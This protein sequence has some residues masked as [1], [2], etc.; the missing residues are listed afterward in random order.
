MHSSGTTCDGAHYLFTG[1]EVSS[2]DSLNVTP[3]DLFSSGDSDAMTL[4]L[5]FSSAHQRNS[6]QQQEV[7]EAR[8]LLKERVRDDWDYPPLPAHQLP[9]RK[10]EAEREEGSEEAVAGFKFHNPSNHDRDALVQDGALD[11]DPVEWRERDYSSEDGS[12]NENVETPVSASSKKSTYKFDGPDSVGVQILDRK[13]ARKRQRQQDLDEEVTWNDGLA[14][15]LARRDAWSGA[16]TS[17]QVQLLE[18]S[19]ADPTTDSASAS[20]S[21]NSTPRSSVSSQESAAVST[22]S[23]TPELEPT[24]TV[25]NT[26]PP[27]PPSDL[28]VPMAPPVLVNHPIRLRINPDLYSEI[29]SKI[30]LQGRTP[31]VPINLLNL[32]GALVQ[33]WKDD[34]EWP[35][36]NAPAEKS[37]ARKKSSGHES[38]LKSGV[39]A[40]GRVLRITSGE[41][42]VG[43]K[44]KG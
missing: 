31:S 43:S 10:R 37:F 33:G 20:A 15:W 9:V 1:A 28:L 36:K 13:L 35:P 34:G 39:R 21:V 8:R 4:H 14:H 23:S 30:I 24:R 7:R 27:A 19:R 12:E 29:Y 6:E 3:S 18:R 42:S 38:S 16:H 22:P 2:R 25:I 40:V 32:T 44:E 5:G 11:F 41:S 26:R 17:Q